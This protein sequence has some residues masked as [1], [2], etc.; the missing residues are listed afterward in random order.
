MN[1]LIY[2]VLMTLL[3]S[4]PLHAQNQAITEDFENGIPS[5]WVQDPVTG[6]TPWSVS[7]SGLSAVTAYS[8]QNYLSLYSP[9]AQGATKIIIPSLV[10]SNY[11]APVFSFYLMQ[12]T[13]GADSNYL[14]DT[15]RVYTRPSSATVW[16]L[17][18]TFSTPTSNW[19]RKEISLLGLISDTIDIAFEYVYGG[20][21]GLGID[22][23]RVGDS[24][25]CYTPNPLGAYRISSNSAALMWEAYEGAL[26]YSL[27]VSTT[28]IDPITMSGDILDLTTTQKPYT[29]TGLTPSTS[30]FYY[31]KADCGDGDVSPWSNAGQFTTLCTPKS[32]PYS[33][34]FDSNNDFYTCWTRVVIP[35]GDW[36]TATNDPNNNIPTTTTDNSHSGTTC[37]KMPY[38]YSLGGAGKFWTTN[39]YVVSPELNTNN[40]SQHQLSF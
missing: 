26:S 10:L 18:Q 3:S 37:I 27:K 12:Q 34:D 24:L 5:T 23:L 30:Y 33:Q 11:S 2:A 21:L 4:L 29:V 15:L 32:L 39:S 36:S 6:V 38:T 7:A 31:V 22:Y 16:S 20:G 40:L 14:R 17:S 25:M 8:G 13:S 19:E 28:P 1:L 9:T 35:V